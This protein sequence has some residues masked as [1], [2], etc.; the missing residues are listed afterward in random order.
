MKKLILL[1]FLTVLLVAC[2]DKEEVNTADNNNNNNN[3]NNNTTTAT[4]NGKTPAIQELKASSA[5][6][7]RKSI[8]INNKVKCWHK[9]NFFYK[10]N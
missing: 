3:N 1:T 2:G 5:S 8:D 10:K 4:N 7:V 9:L 6:P